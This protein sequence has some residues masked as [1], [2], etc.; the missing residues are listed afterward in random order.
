MRE[1]RRTPFGGLKRLG[2]VMG[3]RRQNSKST[4]TP[5]TP[6]KRSRGTL[7]PLRRGTS[8]K[9]MQ[10]IP[11]PEASFVNLPSPLP[12]R[13]PALPPASV[14]KPL[15]TSQSSRQ[16]RRINDERNGDTILPAPN[17]AS[18]LPSANGIQS[19]QEQPQQLKK[20][21]T[22]PL[23]KLPEVRISGMSM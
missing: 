20:Q 16:Q 4:D 2:T 15:E 1:Q 6:E 23:E 19:N 5:P 7:N 21:S 10:T 18:S 8:S 13:E 12:R 11:S 22:V 14:A 3:R 17:R 9:N